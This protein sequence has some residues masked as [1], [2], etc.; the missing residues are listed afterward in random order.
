MVW[1]GGLSSW[2]L[3]VWRSVDSSDKRL[4]RAFGRVAHA[5]ITDD[6][7]G[8]DALCTSTLLT[9]S[10]GAAQAAVEKNA[11]SGERMQDPILRVVSMSDKD[12][13]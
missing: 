4:V 2:L 5:L 10:Y 8:K 3:T 13:P 6:E 7:R 11:G 1:P 9:L 12:A